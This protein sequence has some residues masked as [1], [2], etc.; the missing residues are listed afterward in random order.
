MIDPQDITKTIERSTPLPPSV[1]GAH[2]RYVAPALAVAELVAKGWIVTDAV[3]RVVDE[4]KLRPRD[5]ALKGVRAY[6]Y[7]ARKRI[8]THENHV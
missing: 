7:Y 1:R 8:L 4:M 5:K 6:Y 3:R 2:G